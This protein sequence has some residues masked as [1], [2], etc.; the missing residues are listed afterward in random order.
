[1]ENK[2]TRELLQEILKWVR[3]QG[4]HLLATVILPTILD[5]EEKRKVYEMTDGRNSVDEISHEVGVS[6]GTISN[7]WNRWH[8]KGLLFKEGKRYKKLVS[9]KG[10]NFKKGGEKSG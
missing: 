7:W 8:E 2:D 6:M 9:V 5:S 10:V 3:L 4:H 1:M